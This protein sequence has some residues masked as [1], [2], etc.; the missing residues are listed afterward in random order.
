MGP[1]NERWCYNDVTL[2][3][4]GWAHQKWSQHIPNRNLVITVPA[5]DLAP[6]GARPFADTSVDYKVVVSSAIKDFNGIFTDHIVKLKM[7]GAPFTNMYQF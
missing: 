7:P 2:S 6:N 1:A 5:N 3:V 4:I